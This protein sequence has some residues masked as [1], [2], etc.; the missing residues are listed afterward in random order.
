RPTSHGESQ[1]RCEEQARGMLGLLSWHKTRGVS[2]HFCD[3]LTPGNS[4][5][6]FH[7]FQGGFVSPLSHAQ[8]QGEHREVHE[9]DSSHLLGRTQP[10]ALRCHAR[11]YTRRGCYGCV[12]IKMITI[13]L[14][15]KCILD[16]SII[17]AG[18]GGEA[19]KARCW[20]CAWGLAPLGQ[21]HQ[22]VLHRG[23]VR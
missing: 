2:P 19:R 20:A 1:R 4:M 21:H 16:Q 9:D 15:E 17:R 5:L 12:C 8:R 22:E 6:V 14:N 7:Q 23:T 18:G 13:S 11:E 10:T 3:A